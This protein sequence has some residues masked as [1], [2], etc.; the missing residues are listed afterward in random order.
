[1]SALREDLA[2]LGSGLLFRVGRPEEVLPR[3]LRQVVHAAAAAA[4]AA[5]GQ[6]WRAVGVGTRWGG[7]EEARF[8]ACC[9]G[10]WLVVGMQ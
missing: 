10:C 5:G 7:H 9:V 1:M 6:V 3:L 2:A 8:H 4:A